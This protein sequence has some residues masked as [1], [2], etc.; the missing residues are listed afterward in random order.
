MHRP[1]ARGV[2]RLPQA[3]WEVG[4]RPPASRAGNVAKAARSRVLPLCRAPRHIIRC[5]SL[6]LP[7]GKQAE[8]QAQGVGAADLGHRFSGAEL[9]GGACCTG[10][11]PSVWS[12]HLGCLHSRPLSWKE[13]ARGTL[14][15]IHFFF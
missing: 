1:Q 6:S 15:E 4:T 11:P 12:C 10:R 7:L 2:P 14:F 5:L 3:P 8:V 13:L 9:S